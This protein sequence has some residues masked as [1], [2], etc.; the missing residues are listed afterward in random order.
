MLTAGLSERRA[1]GAGPL[2]VLCCDNL[3]HNGRTVEAIVTAYAHAVDPTLAGLIGAHVAFPG[4]MVDRIV[5]ET[6][7]YDIA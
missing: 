4:T 1:A 3:P 2:T 5:P 6:T 7:D